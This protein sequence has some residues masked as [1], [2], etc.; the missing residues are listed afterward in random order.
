MIGDR[1]LLAF[2]RDYYALF[3]SL[4]WR[5]PAGELLAA[6]GQGLPARTEAAAG[7][8]PLL[9]DG[10]REVETY[11]G[12]V[13]ADRRGEAVAE[14]YTRLFLGPLGHDLNPYESFYL[15]GRVLDRP[16]A[17][18]RGFLAE[19]GFAK[20]ER[21]AEPEDFLG[22]ELDVMRRLVERQG[23]AGDPDR[24]TR[25]LD[26]QAA[27]LKR[28][29]LVWGPSAA[30]DLAEA[31]GARFYRGVGRLLQGF[32]DL[33]RGL[34]EAWGPETVPSL[35]EVRRRFQGAGAWKGPLLDA[36]GPSQ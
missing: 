13:P 32:L 22:F 23:E 29:L 7:L 10:W 34:F 21:Y 11:L 25:W 2:R 3:V 31:P 16:L 36:G 19:I 15:T 35:D 30:R 5:E 1:E 14:E 6:L 28:H 20:D 12:E 26:L 27:F 24:E 18:L 4:L 33:E 8:H 17:V 9:A